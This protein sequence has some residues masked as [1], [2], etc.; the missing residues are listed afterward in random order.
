MRKK[1]KNIFGIKSKK[2]KIRGTTL[3]EEIIHDSTIEEK[4]LFIAIHA[5]RSDEVC[6]ILDGIETRTSN[7][8]KLTKMQE[9]LLKIIIQNKFARKELEFVSKERAAQILARERIS[10]KELIREMINSESRNVRIGALVGIFNALEKN[11]EDSG[12]IWEII[13]ATVI[14]KSILEGRGRRESQIRERVQ[15]EILRRIS[16]GI[17]TKSEMPANDTEIEN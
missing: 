14:E 7:G 17:K 10:D 15:I 6:Q 11:K 5:K 9:K 2:Q 13:G 8:R 1:T 4:A 3:F 12:D 16:S